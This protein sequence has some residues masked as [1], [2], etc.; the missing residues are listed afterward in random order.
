MSAM[1]Q[2]LARPAGWLV[3]FWWQGCHSS[4]SGWWEHKPR[5]LHLRPHPP[6]ELGF[7]TGGLRARR[8]RACTEFCLAVEGR[9]PGSG[10]SMEDRARPQVS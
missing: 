5:A 10:G 9:L 8:S 6:G 2:Q 3:P 1:R 4:R 7:R